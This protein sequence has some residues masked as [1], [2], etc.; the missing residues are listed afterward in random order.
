MNWYALYVKSRH[1]FV[2]HGELL[3]KG[4]EAFLPASR[5][6]RQWKDRKK[7]ID[8]PIFPGYLFVH[9]PP[10]PEAFLNVLKTRGAINLLSTQPG[11]PTPIP[12]EEIDSLK[13]LIESGTELNVFP[14]LKEG[15]K[16]R[17]KRG[18]LTGAE[19]TVT[20]KNDQYIF[21][22]TIELLGRSVGV[23][24]YADDIEAI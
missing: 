7:W 13:L 18:P 15:A 3:K 9:I 23:N 2:T 11:Y 4:L 5:R 22:V 21:L 6:L 10:H 19:G 24:I 20:K 8:F 17:V 1:E 14:S 12:P 16:V